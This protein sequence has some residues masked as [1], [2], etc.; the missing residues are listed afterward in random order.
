MDLFPQQPCVELSI[1]YL[2]VKYLRHSNSEL[3]TKK[4]R[5]FLLE[6]PPASHEYI[7]RQDLVDRDIGWRYMKIP[8]ATIEH[9]SKGK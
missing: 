5:C 8:G 7:D 1:I 3:T 6:L 2:P 9:N 4:T